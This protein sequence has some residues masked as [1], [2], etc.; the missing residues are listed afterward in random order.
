MPGLTNYPNGISS[1]GMPVLPG[2]PPTTGTVYFL[3]NAT[4]A[5]GSDGNS[6]LT[7]QQ[8]LATL[9]AAIA[10][11]T[12]SKGDQVIV[13]PGHAETTTAIPLNIAGVAVIGLGFG[14]N[15]P[16]FTATTA[17]TD[18]INVSAAN[19][20]LMNVRLVGAA[21]GVTALLDI[22]AEVMSEQMLA[23]G[24]GSICSAGKR[25][26]RAVAKGVR[27]PRAGRSDGEI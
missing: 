11:C 22:G 2:V 10:K 12:A 20:S 26:R 1:F 14:R 18:L 24:A 5:G 13:M 25:A 3:C 9:A 4:N 17:A 8:P 19:C 7:P 15:R 16:A 21:S 27:P 6:G 23:I